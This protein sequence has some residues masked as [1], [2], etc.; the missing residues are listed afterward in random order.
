MTQNQ[1]HDFER[2]IAKMHEALVAG[3][4]EINAELVLINNHLERMQLAMRS[5]ASKPDDL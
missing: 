3:L 1:P 4:G 2:A 5:M